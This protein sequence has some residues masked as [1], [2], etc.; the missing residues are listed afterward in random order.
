[1]VQPGVFRCNAPAFN[2]P[3]FVALRLFYEG[4]PLCVAPNYF[5]YRDL[6]FKVGMKRDRETTDPFQTAGDKNIFDLEHSQQHK[7]RLVERVTYIQQNASIFGQSNENSFLRDYLDNA[8]ARF[9]EE[10]ER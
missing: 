10:T 6:P 2:E 3:G 7:V 4:R 1:M 8:V 9:D 5:E